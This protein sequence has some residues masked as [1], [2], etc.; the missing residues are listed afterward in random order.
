MTIIGGGLAGCEAAWQ[1]AQAGIHVFLYEM[2]P[3]IQTGAHIGGGLAEL[4]CSNSLGSKLNDRASGLLKAELRRL[5][6]LLLKC[7]DETSIPAGGA[8]AVDREEFAR[9]VTKK[10]EGHSRIDVIRREATEIPDGAVIIASGPLTSEKLSKAIAELTGEDHLYFYDAIAPLVEFE[11]IDMD[12]AFFASRYGRGEL[13]EGD[14]INCPMTKDE[15]RNFVDLLLTAERS[16][17]RKFEKDIRCGVKTGKGQF[18]EGC[19]PIEV[20]AG[21]GPDALA[22]G[23]LRP[24]GIADPETGRRP[25]AVVQLRRDDV[26][27]TIYNM[28]GFQTNLKV[29]E[30]ALIFRSIPALENAKFIRYGQMHRN[31]FIF[32]PSLLNPTLQFVGKNELFFAGQITGVEGYVGSIATGLLAGI[33]VSKYLRGELLIELPRTTMMGA[34]CHYITHASPIDF[35]P[36]KANFGLFPKL[37]EKVR[38][39]R[40]GR[41]HAYSQR[42]LDQL[43]KL[44][45][46]KKDWNEHLE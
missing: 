24:I 43:D 36:M 17:L 21:R 7:A 44:L 31:T 1:A 4:V 33:N 8:L 20:L 32:S 6:S 14:Y 5:N 22:F 34:L 11:S 45:N 9:S 28:V 16:D 26:A 13:P 15:Y 46:E 38:G 35:Q 37:T 41:R 27:G 25:H 18:F 3:G 39:G 19:L 40:R 29:G 2:R 42:S 23:P 30:Q 12:V 10:I